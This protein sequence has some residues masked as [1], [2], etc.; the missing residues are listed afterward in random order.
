M[1]WLSAYAAGQPPQPGPAT[2]H[3]WRLIACRVTACVRLQGDFDELKGYEEEC[4]VLEPP[5]PDVQADIAS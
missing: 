2:L 1:S 5:L 4:A 3:T